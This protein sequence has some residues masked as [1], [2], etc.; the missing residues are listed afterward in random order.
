MRVLSRE[1]KTGE[2]KLLIQSVDDLWHIYNLVEP[3]DLVIATSFRREE[4]IHDKLRPERMEKKKM[5]IGLRVEKV[6]FH[7]FSD[8]LRVQG[9]IEQA[10]QDL[11]EHHTFNITLKD[12]LSIVK[13]WKEHQL[14]RIEE[15]VRA[16]QEP[17]ITFLA[18]DDEGALLAQLHQYGIQE[19]AEIRSSG[20]GKMYPQKGAKE[21]F[22]AEVISKLKSMDLGD[23]LILLGPGFEKENLNDRIRNK[24]P[25]IASQ[26]Y[27]FST[28][29][30]GMLGIQESLKGG[31]AS[32]ILEKSRVALETRLVEELLSEISRE[33]KYAYGEEEVRKATESG[34]VHTL[35][36]TN[37]MIRN[38]VIEDL[39]KEVERMKGRI[40]VVSAKHEAGKK[41]NSLGGLGALLRYKL[42]HA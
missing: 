25:E 40:V 26:T 1:E 37:E 24:C 34:A 13:K 16:T 17:L 31:I 22:F 11:G 42:H 38:K 30:A 33:G 9:V 3:G 18:I 7:D 4:R 29:H 15:A 2:I 6:E 20:T 12:D 39:L 19:I 10:P 32:E 14:A 21:D 23:A 8:R 35:L 5:R 36:I 28:G 41:L 27:L